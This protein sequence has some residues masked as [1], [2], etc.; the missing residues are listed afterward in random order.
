MESITLCGGWSATS[1]F[2]FS[3]ERVEDGIET[4]VSVQEHSAHLVRL[5]APLPSVC[6]PDSRLEPPVTSLS[7]CQPDIE[8]GSLAETDVES[9][10]PVPD[11]CRASVTEEILMVQVLDDL[12]ANPN[13]LVCASP[14]QGE[15]DFDAGRN[16][17]VIWI[18]RSHFL[19]VMVVF[20]SKAQL[21]AGWDSCCFRVRRLG[22]WV[23]FLM[24]AASF[25]PG[26]RTPAGFSN[27]AAAWSWHHV[28]SLNSADGMK[29][30]ELCQHSPTISMDDRMLNHY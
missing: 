7:I 30:E 23:L 1:P 11:L 20:L 9:C 19:G 13:E 29:T 2:R 27:R 10:S 8:K 12:F 26:G 21:E 4:Y 5:P 24:V 3:C 6:W 15:P 25:R 16:H 14:D 28:V 22:L 17:V 18:S